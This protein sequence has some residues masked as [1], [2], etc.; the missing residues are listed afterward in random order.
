MGTA[1][2]CCTEMVV[3]ARDGYGRGCCPNDTTG[4]ADYMCCR[5]PY[6]PDGDGYCADCVT[7]YH[8]KNG[9][10]VEDCTANSCPSGKTCNTS[11]HECE[12]ACD[13]EAAKTS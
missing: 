5:H 13:M 3:T 2:V 11:T 6:K 7:G 4:V 10:C 1:G 8:M 9:S 12:E